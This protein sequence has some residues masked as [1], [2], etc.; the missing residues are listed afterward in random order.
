MFDKANAI[1]KEDACM[2]FY[3]KTKPL[4]IETDVSG[5]GLIAALLQIKEAIKVVIVMKHQ[6][7]ASLGPLHSPAKASSGQKRIQQY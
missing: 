6:T 5:V 7:V 1:I 4:Y 2:K 3:G